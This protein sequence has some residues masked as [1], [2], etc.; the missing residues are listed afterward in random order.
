MKD[1]NVSN[2]ELDWA[3]SIFKNK[4]NEREFQVIS[5]A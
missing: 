2:M 4:M 3:N 1:S 5:N